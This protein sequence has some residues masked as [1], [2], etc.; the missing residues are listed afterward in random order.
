MIGATGA[1][2][3]VEADRPGT[4]YGRPNQPEARSTVLG[5]FTNRPRI[6]RTSK[7]LPATSVKDDGVVRWPPRA[8]RSFNII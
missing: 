1:I 6:G 4:A 7:I 5:F 3:L 8:P 2:C